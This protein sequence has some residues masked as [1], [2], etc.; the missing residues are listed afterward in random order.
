MIG[1]IVGGI[2]SLFASGKAAVG[3]AVGKITQWWKARKDFKTKS[4]E[5]HSLYFSGSEQKPE[6]MLA[7]EKPKPVPQRIE[8]AKKRQTASLGGAEKAAREKEYDTARDAVVGILSQI[9][10]IVSANAGGTRRQDSSGEVAARMGE[11]EKVISPLAIDADAALPLTKVT[12]QLNANRASQVIAE[13]LTKNEGNTH[14]S[15]S[16]TADPVGWD[17]IQAVTKLMPASGQATTSIRQTKSLEWARIHFLHFDMHGPGDAKWNLAPAKTKVNRDMYD[18]VEDD[19]VGKLK[20]SKKIDRYKTVADYGHPDNPLPDMGGVKSNDRLFPSQV[21]VWVKEDGQEKK[22]FDSGVLAKV[23]D[24]VGTRQGNLLSM[25]QAA[26][27]VL[28]QKFDIIDDKIN[29]AAAKP[30]GLAEL[31][32]R[33]LVKALHVGRDIEKAFKVTDLTPINDALRN[34]FYAAV[35]VKESTGKLDSPTLSKMV[36]DALTKLDALVK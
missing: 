2:K 33:N 4:G 24:F 6:L 22:R 14:G 26:Q 18:D 34:Y 12:F 15:S 21:R 16:V 7:S 35:P 25:K 5:K 17:Y 27:R 30:N 9:H 13:P 10:G 11:I 3:T 23:S 36:S 19:I 29:T 20:K 28:K 32:W 1:K 8:E 31:K